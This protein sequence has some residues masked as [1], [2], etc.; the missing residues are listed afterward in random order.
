MEIVSW[1]SQQAN[2]IAD[3]L[4]SNYEFY[5]KRCPE[6]DVD[7]STIISLTAF[8]SKDEYAVVPCVYRWLRIRN[9]IAEE[10]DEFIGNSYVCELAD[11]G[12]SL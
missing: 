12:S 4:T 2:K 6:G 5:V 7:S 10:R 9:G 1:L 11:V 3:N 8:T